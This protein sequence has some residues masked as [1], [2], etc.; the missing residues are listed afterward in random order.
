ME[1][2]K[3]KKIILYV[4]IISFFGTYSNLLYSKNKG[5]AHFTRIIC[6]GNPEVCR[7]T[8]L[9]LVFTNK[10]NLSIE[11]STDYEDSQSIYKITTNLVDESW[12]SDLMPHVKSLYHKIKNLSGILRKLP[13]KKYKKDFFEKCKWRNKGRYFD[14]IK[15]NDGK[16]EM[17]LWISSFLITD[18]DAQ[19]CKKYKDP[20]NQI[21]KKMIN[22]VKELNTVLA[23]LT[24]KA[25]DSRIYFLRKDFYTNQECQKSKE[26]FCFLNDKLYQTPNMFNLFEKDYSYD[27]DLENYLCK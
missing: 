20:H 10:F 6:N 27:T 14:C 18:E 4:I 11:K 17:D 2:L 16:G 26:D 13:R 15:L 7:L 3:M 21:V 22:G 23:Q 8:S 12:Q 5:S 24:K 9:D 1:D 19:Y 25:F